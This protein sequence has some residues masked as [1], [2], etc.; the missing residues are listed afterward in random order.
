[1][2]AAHT[3]LRYAAAEA[4][5]SARPPPKEQ[6]LVVDAWGYSPPPPPDPAEDAADALIDS[7]CSSCED[8]AWAARLRFYFE[9]PAAI[10][11]DGVDAG[12]VVA[13][14]ALS[15]RFCGDEY[16]GG[17]AG[18]AL[19]I[20]PNCERC[21]LEVLA[22]LR[23]GVCAS[24]SGGT[25]KRSLAEKLGEMLAQPVVRL[26]C[27]DVDESLLRRVCTGLENGGL[28]LVLA[29]VARASSSVIASLAQHLVS[30]E[31]ATRAEIHHPQDAHGPKH[32]RPP[33]GS[34][35]DGPAVVLCFDG[36]PTRFPA[37]LA[38]RAR[39]IL[40]TAPDLHR[41][42]AL[43]LAAPWWKQTRQTCLRTHRGSFGQNWFCSRSEASVSSMT[44]SPSAITSA[45]W[46]G[47][48]DSGYS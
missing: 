40:R 24:L 31:N 29:G 13:E 34:R 48:K 18:E 27:M 28:W 12:R 14:A 15:R 4:A 42:A 11:M 20:T 6:I 35:E 44:M 9:N 43:A 19:F 3:E 45:T 36:L 16:R 2:P 46:L 26:H 25:G 1:M 41:V 37:A 5:L 8:F 17:A 39:P 7:V 47:S 23:V 21:M 33:P 38:A 22:A 32:R 10:A 30:L